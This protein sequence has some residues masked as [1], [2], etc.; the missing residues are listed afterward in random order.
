MV[1]AGGADRRDRGRHRGRIVVPDDPRES[2]MRFQSTVGADF[3][4]LRVLQIDDGLPTWRSPTACRPAEEAARSTIGLFEGFISWPTA[5]RSV[6]RSSSGR[7]DPRT[8]LRI[9]GEACRSA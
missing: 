8:V 7:R 2:L 9:V 3:D 5:P 1:G 6:A 4:S